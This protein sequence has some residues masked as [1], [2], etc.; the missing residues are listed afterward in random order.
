MSTCTLW[1]ETPAARAISSSEAP[2]VRASTRARRYSSRARRALAAARLTR[3]RSALLCTVVPEPRGGHLAFLSG[4]LHT[5]ELRDE[6]ERLSSSGSTCS[7]DIRETLGVGW[8]RCQRRNR[9]LLPGDS[10]GQL[11][12][13]ILVGVLDVIGVARR[14][15]PEVVIGRVDVFAHRH[16]S[17]CRSWSSSSQSSTTLSKAGVRSSSGNR[18]ANARY[19]TIAARSTSSSAKR[20]TRRSMYGVVVNR[21]PPSSGLDRRLAAFRRVSATR[22]G[23]LE[24]SRHY[25][26]IFG[27]VLVM[28]P[29]GCAQGVTP[30]LTGPCF[31]VSDCGFPN[32]AS[33]IPQHFAILCSDMRAPEVK[34][35][36]RRWNIGSDGKWLSSP[37]AYE[38]LGFH[39]TPPGSGL[40]ANHCEPRL[41]PSQSVETRRLGVGRIEGAGVRLRGLDTYGPGRRPSSRVWAA[42]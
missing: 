22:Q 38:S 13:L 42:V 2:D 17:F 34:L 5:P 40:D 10:E 18:S 7:V 33:R 24:P 30:N 4:C 31:R 16:S 26:H 37:L 41:T 9:A 3:A 15:L 27:T 11:A 1:R 8:T 28:N 36:H 14:P 35:E 20:C 6:L 32:R 19:S 29:Q 21:A 39:G 25:T 23:L 12:D